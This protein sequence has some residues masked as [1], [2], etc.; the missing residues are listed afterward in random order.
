MFTAAISLLTGGFGF[1]KSLL[2]PLTDAFKKLEDTKVQLALAKTD[3]EKAIYAAKVSVL[4]S[5]VDLMAKESRVSKLNIYVRT[6]I[7]AWA[8]ILLGKL[9]VWDKALGQWTHGSTDK[10]SPELWHTIWIV[11]GFYFVYEGVNT[12]KK[13]V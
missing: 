9:L 11:L 4:Q 8:S 6:S 10:L 2:A 5:C 7:G 3:E 12:F 1:F 13:M